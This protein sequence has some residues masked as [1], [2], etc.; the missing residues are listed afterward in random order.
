ME[1]RTKILAIRQEF[2]KGHLTHEQAKA[3]VQPLLAEMN[4]KGEKIA[5]K[6]GKKYRALTF[7]YVFR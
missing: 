4:I 5:K 3:Q 2:L 1:Y 6:F 7:G